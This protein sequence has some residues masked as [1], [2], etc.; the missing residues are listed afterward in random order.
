MK[1]IKLPNVPNPDDAL[2]KENFPA[3]NKAI[4]KW[5]TQT[6]GK[7]EQASLNNDSPMDQPFVLGTYA[8]TTSLAG[9]STGTDVSNFIVSLCN[10]MIKK[11]MMKSVTVSHE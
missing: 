11:G 1:Q 5:M 3:Y 10:A 6:K 2:Y 7:L 4:Y 8:L 9:T